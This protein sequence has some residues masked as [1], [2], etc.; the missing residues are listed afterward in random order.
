MRLHGPRQH[1]LCV[2]SGDEG[3]AAG[4]KGPLGVFGCVTFPSLSSHTPAPGEHP[5]ITDGEG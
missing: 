1:R 4:S 3:R 5:E 2:E